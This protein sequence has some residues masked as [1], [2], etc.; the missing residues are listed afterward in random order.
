MNKK[1]VY[2]VVCLVIAICTYFLLYMFTFGK[3]SV[4]NKMPDLKKESSFIQTEDLNQ[5]ILRITT[6]DRSVESFKILLANTPAS[7]EKGLGGRKSIEEN[8]V[9]VF[10]FDEIARHYFW[11]KDMQFSIDIVWL[12]KDKEVVHI[13]RN[14]SPDTFPQSFGPSIDSKYVLEFKAGTANTFGI[15]IGD[16]IAFDEE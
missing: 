3:T 7:R 16:K 15:K 11:M 1:Y 9:M 5:S 2:I 14:I 4:Q 6:S 10:V 12:N 13:E 8:E